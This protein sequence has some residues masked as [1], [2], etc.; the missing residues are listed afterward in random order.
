MSGLTEPEG[1]PEVN[2]LGSG[3]AVGKVE[4][5][6]SKIMFT[7]CLLYFIVIFIFELN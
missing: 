6:L 1:Q 5:D 7:S 4:T 3:A 2:P